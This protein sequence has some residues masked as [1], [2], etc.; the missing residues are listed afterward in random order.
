MN[1]LHAASLTRPAPHLRKGLMFLKDFVVVSHFFVAKDI[2]TRY[3]S[4]VRQK[5]MGY[6]FM[7]DTGPV[8]FA[9]ST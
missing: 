5:V 7:R 6:Y 8:C 2:L 9:K 1:T 3:R 4:V